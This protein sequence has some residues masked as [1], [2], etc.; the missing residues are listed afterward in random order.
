M[1]IYGN[2]RL[3]ELYVEKYELEDNLDLQFLWSLISYHNKYYSCES[4]LDES[5]LEMAKKFEE[6]IDILMKYP[7]VLAYFKC[8]CEINQILVN[9]V[10]IIGD[11]EYQCVDMSTRRFMKIKYV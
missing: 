2:S 10:I 4:E 8:V 3:A 6:R 11:K 5:D 9:E 7:A 1:A